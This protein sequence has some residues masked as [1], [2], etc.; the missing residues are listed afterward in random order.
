MA[1]GEPSAV[2]AR[3]P[4][5]IAQALQT[6]GD[7]RPSALFVDLAPEITLAATPILNNLGYAVVPV[8][9]RWAATPAIVRSETL[10]ARLVDFAPRAGFPTPP[11]GVVFLLD[12]RRF[13]PAGLAPAGPQPA[14][15]VR[16]LASVRR[17]DNRYQYPVCRFPPV[18]LLLARGIQRT[19]WVPDSIAPDLQTYV[20]RLEG[21]GLG[22]RPAG[23][24]ELVETA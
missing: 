6:R 9:Q 2:A 21:A 11:R 19:V 12:G 5:Q 20:A 14:P 15:Q 8:V 22:P 23:S 18:D 10:L 17:F 1:V 16:R 7:D 24:P 3:L 4:A 13:G